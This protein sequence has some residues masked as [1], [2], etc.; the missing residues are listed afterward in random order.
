MYFL[1]FCCSPFIRVK[2]LISDVG[3]MIPNTWAGS[4]VIGVSAALLTFAWST[5]QE[6]ETLPTDPNGRLTFPMGF[7]P[8]SMFVC[9]GLIL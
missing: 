8:E 6:C 4:R 1:P 2:L 3:I 5:L 9:L 7:C